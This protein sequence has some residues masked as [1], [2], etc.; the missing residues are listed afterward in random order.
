MTNLVVIGV[1]AWVGFSMARG[2]VVLSVVRLLLV[3]IGIIFLI[4]VAHHLML[5]GQWNPE[6]TL[7]N[8]VQNYIPNPQNALS[9]MH[10]LTIPTI[11]Q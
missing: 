5:L 1:I 10:N 8:W 2:S 3:G 4:V 11:N 6:V 9:Q 7:Y